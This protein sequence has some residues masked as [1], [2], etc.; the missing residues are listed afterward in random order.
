MLWTFSQAKIELWGVCEWMGVSWY[1]CALNPL[2]L[3]AGL[4]MNQ[5]YCDV[6]VHCS[7]LTNLHVSF[8]GHKAKGEVRD[9]VRK[10]RMDRWRDVVNQ[11]D[12]TRQRDGATDTWV[13]VGFQISWLWSD[14]DGE[15][16]VVRATGFAPALN[17]RGLQR[18]Y[19]WAICLRDIE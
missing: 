6:F 4:N 15:L 9:K 19:G 14:E 18:H 11:R 16:C 10:R 2:C 7:F 5:H 8:Q 17:V 12:K 13:D 1:C 3:F